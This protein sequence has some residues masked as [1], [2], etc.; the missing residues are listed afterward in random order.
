[1]HLPNRLGIVKPYRRYISI[2]CGRDGQQV[3]MHQ[4]VQHLGMSTIGFVVQLVVRILRVHYSVV[5]DV[6]QRILDKL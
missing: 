3:I 2:C 4:A 5:Q 6:V 1:M